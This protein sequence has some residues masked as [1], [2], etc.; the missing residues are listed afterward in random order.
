MVI[1]NK[2]KNIKM[3]S[4]ILIFAHILFMSML[5]M[6]GSGG[7]DD[8][9]AMTPD[10]TGSRNHPLGPSR[11]LTPHQQL[12][13]SSPSISV[14]A[15]GTPSPMRI[16]RPATSTITVRPPGEV[17]QQRLISLPSGTPIR[18]FLP[19]TSQTLM[20]TPI[21]TTS[22]LTSTVSTTMPRNFA[23]RPRII[24]TSNNTNI[25]LSS[26]V[27][28]QTVRVGGGG[29]IRMAA[30]VASNRNN[31][32]TAP[33]P[34]TG[35]EDSSEKE[36]EGGSSKEPPPKKGRI[37]RS[38]VHEEF[39]EA[40]VFHKKERKFVEG[41]KCTHCATEFSSKNKSNLED[42]LRVFHKDVYQKVLGL[43]LHFTSFLLPFDLC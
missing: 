21:L 13:L 30:A 34:R 43:L 14:R 2:R 16:F 35:T 12:Q 18:L 3:I 19:G 40:Q 24:T 29:N 7:Q 8:P 28:L 31:S 10:R 42:H 38:A 1:G 27:G 15:V 26:A 17:T 4:F 5:Q 6:S 22:S 32:F 36:T 20:R 25:A 37:A 11:P 23:P 33:Q 41:R 9:R 39:N